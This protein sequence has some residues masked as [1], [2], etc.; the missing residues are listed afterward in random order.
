MIVHFTKYYQDSKL[1]EPYTG[2]DPGR[3]PNYRYVYELYCYNVL[4][5]ENE[6]RVLIDTGVGP[7]IPE[8]YLG[9]V[10]LHPV[11][12]FID[13]IK[14]YGTQIQPGDDRLV[15][16]TLLMPT[17]NA[18]DIPAK[19]SAVGLLYLKPAVAFEAV[20]AEA[21]PKKQSFNINPN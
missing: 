11:F 13:L 4:F 20:W 14:S 7:F 15:E 6:E 8:G 16:L 12:K 17:G 10:V 19:G 3:L 2:D 18:D 5:F 21:Q 9:A 1:P